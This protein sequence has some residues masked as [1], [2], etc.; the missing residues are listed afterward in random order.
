MEK[1]RNSIKNVI[2]DEKTIYYDCPINSNILIDD[3]TQM[4]IKK[5]YELNQFIYELMDFDEYKNT[6]TYWAK[7]YDITEKNTL[8]VEIKV[9][10]NDKEHGNNLIFLTDKC[11][12]DFI[13]K[14][15]LSLATSVNR[16]IDKRLK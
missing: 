12:K 9:I 7:Q 5:S 13:K 10:Y 16:R 2:E 6:E 8:S 1:I 3:C 4:V 11:P 14:S 15:V